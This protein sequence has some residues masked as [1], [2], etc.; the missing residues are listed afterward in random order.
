MQVLKGLF[1][2]ERI[3]VRFIL[4]RFTRRNRRI[5]LFLPEIRLFSLNQRL[6][7]FLQQ[8]LLAPVQKKP[9]QKIAKPK[10][11]RIDAY[12]NSVQK[13]Y[14][15]GDNKADYYLVFRKEQG[16]KYKQ[17]GKTKKLMYTDKKGR[18]GRYY[19]YRIQAV[20]SETRVS[21]RSF[22]SKSKPVKK[23]CRKKPARVAYIGDSV[24][25]GFAA[26]GALNSNE[27]SFAKVSLFVQQ[28]KSTFL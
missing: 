14:W 6:K 24:M 23:L 11:K 28:I 26:Y 17:I 12:E 5:H 1:Q 16:G 19:Y 27:R 18:G 7:L 4:R 8:L 3:T 25:S 13:I 15:T 21:A 9:K 2:T 22:S 20:M 10:I